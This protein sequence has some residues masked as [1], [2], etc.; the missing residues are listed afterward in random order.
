MEGARADV[1]TPG[2]TALEIDHFLSFYQNFMDEFDLY[3]NVGD[4]GA[5]SAREDELASD[6]AIAMA[7]LVQ[8]TEGRYT[9]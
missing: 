8:E 5:S 4:D 9:G 2:V 6:L 7:E 1:P 3:I